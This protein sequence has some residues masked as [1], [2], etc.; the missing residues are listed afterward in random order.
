MDRKPTGI[1]GFDELIQ[2][3]FVERSIN[4]VAGGPGCGKTI[5]CLQYLWNGAT[6]FGEPGLFV[7]F[8]ENLDDLKKDALAFG[9]DFDSLKETRVDFIYFHPYDVRDIH[10]CLL[11]LIKKSGAKRVVFD[12]TS[13]YGMTLE[14]AFEVRKGLYDLAAILRKHNCVSILTSE[15]VEGDR[16]EYAS[17]FSRFGVEE[18][19]ADSIIVI[20]FESLGGQ[21]PRSIQVRKMR[22]TKNDE[23]VHPLEITSQGLIV[24][25]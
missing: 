24:H 12:S 25:H 5:F 7:S 14:S 8:E 20:T 1:S 3:G 15:I 4:L 6:K 11:E 19:L 10:N 18:F 23:G 2:G 17:R 13:V 9:W 22:R 16:S 21:I